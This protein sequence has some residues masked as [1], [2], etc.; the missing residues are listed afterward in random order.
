MCTIVKFRKQS[1]VRFG[2]TLPLLFA[3]FLNQASA[4]ESKPRTARAVLH[5]TATV[6][7]VVTSTP[8]SASVYVS[9]DVTFSLPLA[10]QQQFTLTEE[11]RYLRSTDSL[12]TVQGLLKTTTIVQH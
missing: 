9:H 8:P 11:V 12:G 1:V 7:P 2:L 10:P 6:V 4:Q 5:I 3:F